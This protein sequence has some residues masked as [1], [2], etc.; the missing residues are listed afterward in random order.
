MPYRTETTILV[1]LGFCSS[2]SSGPFFFVSLETPHKQ[3]LFQT[4]EVHVALQPTRKFALY[5]SLL[6][7][8]LNWNVDSCYLV[9]LLSF[10]FFAPGTVRRL[11]HSHAS[12]VLAPKLKLSDSR[13]TKT[14]LRAL[15]RARSA[16]CSL[17]S[18]RA[19]KNI[20]RV[21]C[22]LRGRQRRRL[23]YSQRVFEH[24]IRIL[25]VRLSGYCIQI[26]WLS[27]TGIPIGPQI[28]KHMLYM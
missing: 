14:R 5:H 11:A 25:A 19:R 2:F 24:C 9:T 20:T 1:F 22:K 3:T 15:A 26:T 7:S 4:A 8:R 28:S 12:L 21:V 10:S 17:R 13:R 18:R 27:S 6:C 16:R 23:P